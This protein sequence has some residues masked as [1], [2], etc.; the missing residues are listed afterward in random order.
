MSGS[1]STFHFSTHNMN[2]L[3]LKRR[4]RARTRYRS[5]MQSI[6]CIDKQKKQCVAL[7][8]GSECALAR[9]FS[10]YNIMTKVIYKRQ[11]FTSKRRPYKN[12]FLADW[13]WQDVLNEAVILKG[14][15]KSRA[16]AHSLPLGN[17]QHCFFCLS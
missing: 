5:A 11:K 7:P 1:I 13:N 10:V 9:G 17:A 15:E 8:S 4:A 12:Y 16:S 6:A 3:I 2:L 14:T